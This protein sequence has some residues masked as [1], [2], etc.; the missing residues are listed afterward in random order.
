[1]G[2]A[3]STRIRGRYA[4]LTEN[5]RASPSR[6]EAFAQRVEPLWIAA[7]GI[8]FVVLG[9]LIVPAMIHLAGRGGQVDTVEWLI[10][11]LLLIAYA[12]LVS[13][14]AAV[15][16]GR[17]SPRT[18]SVLRLAV[19]AV[20]LV[21]LVVYSL[22]GNRR[23]LVMAVVASLV[24]LAALGYATGPRRRT[25]AGFGWALVRFAPVIIA[26][27]FAWMCAAGLVSWGDAVVWVTSSPRTLLTLIAAAALTVAA[28]RASR[29]EISEA[30][31]WLQWW[32][33]P[34]I[35]ALVAFSFRTYPVIEL[36]HWGFY[37]GPIE[38]VRQG[39]LLL[40][41]TPSQ[42]GLRAC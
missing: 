32:D 23:F 1:M 17:L 35:A 26:G 25:Q 19:V 29:E 16:P 13:V 38:Q 7:L 15:L 27:A 11:M 33:Y 21:E 10:Y 4:K 8:Q 39:G 22:S 20:A 5:E 42:Y 14:F 2:R 9:P 36:Y 24:T 28:L 18:I 37:I 3:A 30:R 6:L 34:A 41:D 31:G 12:P 40:W